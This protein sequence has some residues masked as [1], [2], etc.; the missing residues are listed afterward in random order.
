M[1]LLHKKNKYKAIF[2][3]K[4]EGSY[5]IIGKRRFNPSN[6]MIRFKKASYIIDVSRPTFI[7]ALKM[8]YFIEKD[9][10]QLFFGKNTEGTGVSPQVVDMIMSQKIVHDL[11]TNLAGNAFAINIMTLIFGGLMG[12]LIGF[13]IA[14]YV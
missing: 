1:N 8:F 6:K 3:I 13:I 12:G 14:G 5:S 2:L 10:T 9:K 4:R 11:T 7:R